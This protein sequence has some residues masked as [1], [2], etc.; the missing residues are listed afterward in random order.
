MNE[1]PIAII[2]AMDRNHVIGKDGRL[3]WN[4]PE[5]M[6]WFVQHTMHNPVVMGRRTFESMKKPLRDRSNIVISRNAAF[7][8]PDGVHLVA[9]VDEALKLGRD[10][11][12]SPLQKVFVIGGAQVFEQCF[13]WVSLLYLTKI[14]TSYDGDTRFPSYDEIQWEL[15]SSSSL[16]S[17]EGIPLRFEIYRRRWILKDA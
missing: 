9:N 5:D 17:S 2:V 8:V 4:I 10:L 6:K 16:V 14:D 7:D 1:A 12:E 3:P 15:D 11:C 13:D